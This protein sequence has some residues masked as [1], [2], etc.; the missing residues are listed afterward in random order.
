M[1]L[2]CCVICICSWSIVLIKYIIESRN[3]HIAY[4]TVVP[5]VPVAHVTPI[6]IVPYIL[7]NDIFSSNRLS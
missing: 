2:T 1:I 6:I 5:V 7:S 4:N 3:N